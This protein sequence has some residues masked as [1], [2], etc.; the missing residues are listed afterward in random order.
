MKKQSQ[1]KPNFLDA[2]MN[3]NS[4]ITKDYNNE[5]RTINNAKQTQSNPISKAKKCC[6][7]ESNIKIDIPANCRS[8]AQTMNHKPSKPR[9]TSHE[10]REHFHNRRWWGVDKEG[11]N[12]AK[13]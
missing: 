3:V 6:W 11:L 10:I 5:Q 1:N 8:N 4:F 12:A 2:Q 7:R 13:G 9:T